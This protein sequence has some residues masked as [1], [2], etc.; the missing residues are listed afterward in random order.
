MKFWIVS[1]SVVV[2]LYLESTLNEVEITRLYTLIKST[3]GV[4]HRNQCL[5]FV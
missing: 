2:V 5:L 1:R 3:E 4:K